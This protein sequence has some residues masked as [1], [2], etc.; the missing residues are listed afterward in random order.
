M[1]EPSAAVK[2]ATRSSDAKKSPLK[3]PH[4]NLPEEEYPQKPT[5]EELK[6]MT[7]ISRNAWI[8]VY[9]PADGETFLGTLQGRTRDGPY[10]YNIHYDDGEKHVIDLRE[11]YFEL[12]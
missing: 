4:Q 9:W 5:E 7:N 10:H 1:S 3:S 11:E 6:R 12:L 2:R 8:S